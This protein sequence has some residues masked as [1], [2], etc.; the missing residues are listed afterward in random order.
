MTSRDAV[1][2][3]WI[4]SMGGLARSATATGT[5]RMETARSAY[6]QSF[7]L[8]HKCRVCRL[9]KIDQTLPPDEISRR[10]AALFRLHMRRLRLRADK[11]RRL[12]EQLDAEAAKLAGL[13][14]Q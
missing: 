1:E 9:V 3:R 2:R 11:N 12:A 4:A 8:G 13:G 7:N 14:T 6:R 10:G 5:E